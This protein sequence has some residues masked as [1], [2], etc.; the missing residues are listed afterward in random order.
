VGIDQLTESP[1]LALIDQI[2]RM[3]ERGE[4]VLGLHIGE[5]DFP[6]PPGIREAAYRAMNEG[7]THYTAAQGMADLRAAVAARVER[8]NQIAASEA[9]VVILPAKF[10]IYA[11]LLATTAPG[12][13]VLLPDP[14]YL[15]EQ[16]IELVGGRSVYARTGPEYALDPESLRAAVTARTRL[17]VLVSPGNPTGR[18]LS[19]AEVDAALE[20]AR[21]A[22]LTVVS[23]ETYESLVYEGTHTSP[24][25]RAGPQ[26][27]V[28]TIGSF[29]KLYAMTGWRAGYAVAPPALAGRLVKVVEHTLSCVPPFIQ[30]ACFWALENAGGDEARFRAAFRERRD[31]LLGRL[32]TVEGLT[33]F[34][35]G[36]AFYVF[37]EYDARVGSAEFCRGLLASERL[38][39][40]PGVAFG[41]HGEGHVRISYSSPIPVLDEGVER[42]ARFLGQVR[43]RAA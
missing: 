42:L 33:T 24:A 40:V 17:L 29:S 38:A 18:V 23:D 16:P 7:L 35:P 10:A 19:R 20:V 39:L 9:N 1:I 3:R 41:P 30:R 21:E 27:P 22:H 2:F 25:S 37:P 32:A 5:P 6:T 11:T 8:R 15:F 36:G 13:E 26:V 4:E 43:S 34:R 14:T 31:H 12:D 28:V